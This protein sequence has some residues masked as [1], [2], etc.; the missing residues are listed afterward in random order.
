MKKFKIVFLSIFYFLIL[1]NTSYTMENRILFKVN[2]EIITSLDIFNEIRY[3]E[4]INEKFKF[5]EK[6][7]AFE[8]AKKS[9]IREKIKEIELKKIIKEI[10]IDNK[11][12]DKLLIDYF[13]KIQIN[14]ISNFENYFNSKGVNPGVIKKKIT[15]EVMWNQLIFS[16]YKQNLKIDK[17]SIITDLKKNNKQKEYLL[18]EILF[19]VDENEK[20]DEKFNLI[21]SQI[22]KTNFFDTALIY[23]ISNSSNK[24]GDIGWVK[25]LSLNMK[26]RDLL[27]KT[28]INDYTNPIVIPGGFLILKIENI[29]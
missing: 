5:T 23:S 16:K 27:Q 26:I 6:N 10:K 21:K 25:E 19:N 18:S 1:I 13:K 3:L 24:G 29:R 14:S 7:Q 22:K 15:I 9:L 28:K 8:I 12:L 11:I 20:L 4:T 17:E 2:N